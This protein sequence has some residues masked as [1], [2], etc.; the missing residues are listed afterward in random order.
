MK[1]VVKNERVTQK[2]HRS[3][4]KLLIV[5]EKSPEKKK[6]VYKT[7]KFK[8]RRNSWILSVSAVDILLLQQT[9]C[10]ENVFNE[11]YVFYLLKFC[12]FDKH[13]NAPKFIK[14]CCIC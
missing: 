6:V 7:N 13:I 2:E 11:H 8:Q 9:N 5:I 14:T 3:F 10:Y 1:N 12:C 4:P